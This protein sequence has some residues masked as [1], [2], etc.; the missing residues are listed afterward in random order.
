MGPL[1]FHLPPTSHNPPHPPHEKS[2]EIDGISIHTVDSEG[3]DEHGD[4]VL[5]EDLL[6]SYDYSVFS[7][8]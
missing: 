5:V 2:D 7:R 3:E 6:V 1:P 4:L 8:F